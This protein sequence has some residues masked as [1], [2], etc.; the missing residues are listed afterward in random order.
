LNNG[1]AQAFQPSLFD[2]VDL[3]EVSSPDFPGERLIVCR[4]PL[5]AADRSRTREELLQATEEKLDAVVT[6]TRR[7]SRPLRGEK[8][9]ALRVGKILGRSKVGK[10][11]DITITNDSFTY[12]RND[13]RIDQEKTL[14]GF[15]VV[16]T[17]V[18]AGRM[19]PEQVVESY[20]G[21]SRLEQAFRM[22]KS[23]DLKV[24]PIFHRLEDRV[25][26]HFFLCMLAYYVDWHLRTALA[27]LLFEDDDPLGAQQLRV[28]IVQKAQV[29]SSA[30]HKA[31][32]KRTAD[33]QQAQSLATL[34]DHLACIALNEHQSNIKGV[35]NTFFK[36]TE[37][38]K[39][40]SRA[41][42]LLK[43]RPPV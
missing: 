23:I 9:I 38:D 13:D 3:A 21:L 2:E 28:S 35:D 6:A 30:A 16:R 32:T 4:N 19:S 42:D 5:L 41:F 8:K 1:E 29:S 15:Y 14:D 17:S 25:R 34:L 24:R 7:E 11:F 37:L 18:P 26:A 22:M 12:E 27:P 10:H 31:A 33:D 40:S 43:V 39:L 36:V 20:K